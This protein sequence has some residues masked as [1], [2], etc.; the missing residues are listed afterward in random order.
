MHHAAST[1]GTVSYERDG[2]G[3]GLA[4]VHG[5]GGDARRVFDGVVDHFATRHQVLRPNLSGSGATVDDGRPLAVDSIADQVAAV[6]TETGDGP[7]DLLGFSL[8]AVAAAALAAE[9]P[10]L[11]RRLVLVGGWATSSGPRDTL[12]L[13]TWSRLLETDRDL[14]RRFAALTGYSPTGLD[15]FT[16]EGIAGYLAD[17][18][19]PP[20]GIVRQM[21]LAARVEIQDRLA[22]IAAP[23]LVVGLGRDAMIPVEGSRMLHAGIRDSRLV[24]LPEAGHMDWFSAPGDLLRAVDDFLTQGA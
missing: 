1:T 4:L 23:T 7:V 18:D 14:F 17:D 2:D 16:H 10:A 21:D 20:E 13:Q 3:P 5:V 6:I 15:A 12:Y 11:V 8:G 19:W 22:A 24:E 9:R